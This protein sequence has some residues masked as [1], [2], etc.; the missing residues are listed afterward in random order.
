MVQF[1]IIQSLFVS[2]TKKERIVSFHGTVVS[3][4]IENVGTRQRDQKRKKK[5]NAR[6]RPSMQYARRVRNT[7]RFISKVAIYLY[8]QGSPLPHC[9]CRQNAARQHSTP[10]LSGRAVMPNK[11]AAAASGGREGS[12]C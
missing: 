11:A 12:V 1:L 7:W 5:R 2:N 6:W 4:N 10:I 8:Y 9:G 3:I